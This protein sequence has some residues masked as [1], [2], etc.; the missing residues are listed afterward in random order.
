MKR[1]DCKLSQL[2]PNVQDAIEELAKRAKLCDLVDYL[3]KPKPEG[4]D[5]HVSMATLSRF[6]RRRAEDRLK[7]NA[8]E[9]N[10]V[11]SGLAAV[12]NPKEFRK[13]TMAMLQ[14]RMYEEAVATGDAKSVKEAYQMLA[15]EDAREKALEL[16]ARRTVVAEENARSAKLKVELLKMN[17][18]VALL[19]KLAQ[20]LSREGTAEEIL[21]EA[22]QCLFGGG[23]ELMRVAE[24]LALP[25]GAVNQAGSQ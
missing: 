6:L 21:Q 16:E 19:P 10:E 14:Q 25:E 2:A 24:T 12:T 17:A 9:I 11:V 8:S 4:F 18:A 13:G 20:V 15:E 23:G 5:V 3:G 7:E 1:S 22:R